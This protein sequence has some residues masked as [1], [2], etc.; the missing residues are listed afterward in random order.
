MS[1]LSVNKYIAEKYNLVGDGHGVATK[2]KTVYK[3]DNSTH[4][5]SCLDNLQPEL[6]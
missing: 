4:Y 3:F 6:S 5:Q 2:V 1:L